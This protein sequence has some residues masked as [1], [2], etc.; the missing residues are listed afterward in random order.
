MD[1]LCLPFLPGVSV[2]RE[3]QTWQNRGDEKGKMSDAE[4][5]VWHFS[6]SVSSLPFVVATNEKEQYPFLLELNLFLGLLL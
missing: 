2:S 6:I 3:M 1:L 4:C 5:D